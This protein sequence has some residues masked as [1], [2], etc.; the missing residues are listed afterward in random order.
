VVGSGSTPPLAI[1][2]LYFRCNSIGMV[3]NHVIFHLRLR[4]DLFA[5]D[6]A[7]ARIS[8]IWVSRHLCL[9]LVS[10][11]DS[12]LPSRRPRQVFDSIPSRVGEPAKTCKIACP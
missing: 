11:T 9:S 2:V 3:L 4:H 1:T 10:I 8:R 12:M 5:A 7:F 6:L